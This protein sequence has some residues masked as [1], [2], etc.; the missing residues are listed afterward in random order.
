[1]EKIL[2]VSIVAVILGIVSILTGIIWNKIITRKQ[3]KALTKEKFSKSSNSD[4]SV[5][6][7]VDTIL[8]QA[9][10]T[11]MQRVDVKCFSYSFQDTQPL[12]I[13]QNKAQNK[14]FEYKQRFDKY[15]CKE[16]IAA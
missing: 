8:E 14:G 7:K 2:I 1:M 10:E 3:Q 13:I 9:F 15:S 11:S 5:V 16:V 4:V 12:T 6:N